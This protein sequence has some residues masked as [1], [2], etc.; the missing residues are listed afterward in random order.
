MQSSKSKLSKELARYVH[1]T[2]FGHPESSIESS[3]RGRRTLSSS[4]N[5]KVVK[6]RTP[7]QPLQQSY[8][9]RATAGVDRKYLPE[10]RM[11]AI[12]RRSIN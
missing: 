6:S 3:K 9:G 4:K 11:D 5:S 10:Y 8:A 1:E 12:A 7:E 2:T